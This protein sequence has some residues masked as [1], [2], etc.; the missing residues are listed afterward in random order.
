MQILKQ[1]AGRK[2]KRALAFG[3]GRALQPAEPPL[4][5]GVGRGKRAEE[6]IVAVVAE[7]KLRGQAKLT[8]SARCAVSFALPK[9][10]SSAARIAT[11]ATTTSNSI[12]VKARRII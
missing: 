1:R 9:T 12:N 8:Q 7:V 3:H 11:M 4:L 5:A 6:K 10:G 2:V